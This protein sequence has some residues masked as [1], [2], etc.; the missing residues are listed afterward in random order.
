M[1]DVVVIGDAN[2]DLVL[3]GD[4][5]P[6]FGQVE[7]LL[8][9][10]DL[11]LGSSAGICAS[12]LAR[13]GID[14]KGRRLFAMERAEGAEAGPHFLERDVRADD[15]DDVIRRRHALDGLLGNHRNSE[16]GIR[17]AE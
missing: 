17:N 7:Q 16:C 9:S 3:R 2:L 1:P 11:V 8:E 12:G 14:V 13:L 15:I 10:A 6:R 5:V 4:V